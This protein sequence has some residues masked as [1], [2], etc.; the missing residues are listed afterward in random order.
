MVR[1]SATSLDQGEMASTVGAAGVTCIADSKVNPGMAQSAVAPITKN[2]CGL[3]INYVFVV[4]VIHIC[5]ILH[6]IGP[7]GLYCQLTGREA[8]DTEEL[9]AINRLAEEPFPTMIGNIRCIKNH[10]DKHTRPRSFHLR[11]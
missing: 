9:K 7:K 1:S 6:L 10:E 2:R 4:L 3:H 8:N 11:S 5:S